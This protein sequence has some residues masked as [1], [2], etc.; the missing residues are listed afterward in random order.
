MSDNPMQTSKTD[1]EGGAPVAPAA[2]TVQPG[3]EGPGD[4]IPNNPSP[5]RGDLCDCF[6]KCQCPM[7]LWIL[8]CPIL[9]L[10][11]IHYKIATDEGKPKYAKYGYFGIIATIIIYTILGA[12]FMTIGGGGVNLLYQLAF[13][14]AFVLLLTLYKRARTIYNVKGN[15]CADCCGT[16]CCPDPCSDCCDAVF[17]TPCSIGR[18]GHHVFNYDHTESRNGAISFEP[19][20]S[21]F[22]PCDDLA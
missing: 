17:C 20:V 11:Q 21:D 6:C 12:L 2:I 9:V 3:Q 10:A 1:L 13:V 22:D 14:M 15:Y 18:L 5:W 7:G 8:M 16:S 19:L 4:P